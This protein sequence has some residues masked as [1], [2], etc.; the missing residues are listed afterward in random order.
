MLSEAM[1]FKRT[2]PRKKRYGKTN[3]GATF[4]HN[5]L[6]DSLRKAEKERKARLKKP[7]KAEQ[8]LRDQ[9]ARIRLEQ[10]LAADLDENHSSSVDPMAM[11]ERVSRGRW[12]AYWLSIGLMFWGIHLMM[13]STLYWLWFVPMLLPFMSIL[14]I[15]SEKPLP[16]GFHCDPAKEP[17][18]AA[19]FFDIWSASI[20]AAFGIF[21]MIRSPEIWYLFIPFLMIYLVLLPQKYKQWQ[22][23]EK[24]D[25]LQKMRKK[26]QR[27]ARRESSLIWK[28]LKF[29]FW[30]GLLWVAWQV[31]SYLIWMFVLGAA[32]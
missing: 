31:A 4:I 16:L 10:Q 25:E 14:Q 30:L 21:L 9:R 28:G 17:G 6:V 20:I 26:A 13:V 29:V 24:D 1:A 5:M 15:E 2:I 12:I 3:R 8:A 19:R 27:K 18:K 32:K 7:T 11:A 23:E 22:K